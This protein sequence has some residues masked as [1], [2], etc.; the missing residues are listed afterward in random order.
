MKKIIKKI[1]NFINKIIYL[2]DK[3][4]II[5]ITKFFVTIKENLNNDNKKFEKFIN[6]KSSLLFITLILAISVFIAVDSKTIAMLE[7]SAEV[8]YSQPV[9]IIYNEEAYVLEGSPETV[10]ITLIGRRSDLYLA[11]QIPDHEITIDL[12]GLKPGT[13]KVPLKYKRFLS[14]INYKLDPSVATISILPKVSEVR[15]I[16]VD[17]LNRDHL[18]SKLI[19]KRS[20]IN[21]DEVII[22]GS[23][24][25]LNE[26]AT[27]KA[28][29]DIDDI[30]D[31]AVG[32]IELKDL[33]LIA[34]DQSGD[35]ID[36]EIVPAKVNA[37]VI[38]SSPNKIVPIKIIP[39]GELTFGKA[40]STISSSVNEVTIYSDEETL[41]E[42]NNV[43][44]NID[45]DG[46]KEDKEY[47][48][49]LEKPIGVRYMD[50]GVVN[51]TVV[52]EN[53]VTR[54][55]ENVNIEY[56]NLGEEYSVNAKTEKDRTVTVVVKGV[57]S[58]LD[59]IDNETIIAYVDLKGYDV[60]EHEVDVI[61][62]K[63]DVK[64]TYVPKTKKVTLVIK[65]K[66]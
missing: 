41:E 18:D 3:K 7:T 5:P 60:G 1:N 46:L 59:E 50:V 9:E 12:S 32:E 64:I 27:V 53:E 61:V 21:R 36:V 40:I 19:I 48:I 4:V 65:E 24:K 47:N 22:K 23:E 26:V 45:V 58:V 54:E 30:V 6:R 39:N 29:I 13:H 11:K 55:F 31:P 62:E 63:T 51:I 43:T 56:R 15:T 17:L 14:S 49:T 37:I 44:L 25:K 42:I 33:P 10:D 20:E 52:I 57:L 16:D 38:I 28:L 2:I 35:I 8:L 34:Y 66:E